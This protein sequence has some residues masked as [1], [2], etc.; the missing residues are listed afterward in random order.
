M[1]RFNVISMVAASMSKLIWNW[2]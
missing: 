2:Q 1:V